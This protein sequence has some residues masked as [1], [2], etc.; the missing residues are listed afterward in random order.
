MYLKR[1]SASQKI[2]HF[3]ISFSILMLLITGLPITFSSLRWVINTF[4]GSDNTMLLHRFFALI[5]LASVVYFGIYF[6]LERLSGRG[7]RILS[8]DLIKNSIKDLLW[9]LN[10]SK[11][12][13]KFDKYDWIMVADIIGVPI[14][15]IIIGI[16]GIFM[17]FPH[18]F[19]ANNPA[20]FFAFRTIH[21]FFAVFFLFFVFAHA[22]ILHLTPGNFPMN[23]SIFTGLIEAKKAKVEHP[24]WVEK[25]EKINIEPKPHKF[26]PLGYV[27]FAI[28][29]IALLLLVY[30]TF[31]MADEGLAGLR[32][33]GDMFV[34]VGLNLSMLVVFAYLV[35]TIYGG[36]YGIAKG[37]QP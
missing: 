15:I 20:L 21:A 22:G 23:M 30:T 32:V 35:A 36:L 2:A 37:R 9:A 4:G 25:A 10:L 1:F 14:L 18:L 7:E 13:P 34:S 8:A 24:L 6:I 11:E 3:L 27:A 16:T 5:L 33:K 26:N 28:S 17:W 31:V 19:V 12:R 29:F